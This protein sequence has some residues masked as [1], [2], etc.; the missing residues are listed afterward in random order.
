MHLPGAGGM[1]S[2]RKEGKTEAEARPRRLGY[3]GSGVAQSSQ[4]HRVCHTQADAY[5]RSGTIIMLRVTGVQGVCPGPH[6]GPLQALWPQG[7]APSSR[8]E[9]NQGMKPCGWHH[10]PHQLSL[11]SR[12]MLG[13]RASQGPQGM[14]ALRERR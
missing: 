8:S 13:H 1:N 6:S 7:L 11:S 12:G 14:W 9:E 3:A 2:K 10:P 5:H 4:D